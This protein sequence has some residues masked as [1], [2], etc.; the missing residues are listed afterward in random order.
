MLFVHTLFSLLL[1][2]VPQSHFHAMDTMGGGFSAVPVAA[3]A[4]TMGG[5]FKTAPVVT[6]LDTMG[7]G[8]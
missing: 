1:S 2:L 6:A 4:D 8:F 5:G 7:G 3:P